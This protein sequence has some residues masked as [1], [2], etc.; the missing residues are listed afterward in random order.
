MLGVGLRQFCMG[1]GLGTTTIGMQQQIIK[2]NTKLSATLAKHIGLL[3]ESPALMQQ[4]H[5]SLV[6]MVL[7][8]HLGY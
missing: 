4:Q 6:Q 2:A 8:N 5:D 7:D 3:H 1:T